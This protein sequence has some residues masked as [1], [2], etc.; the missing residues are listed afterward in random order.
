[1]GVHSALA[2]P[3][4][5]DDDVIGAINSY[6][7]ARDAFSD[8]AVQLSCQFAGPAAVSV[9]NALLLA[10]AWERTERL[11][12]ALGSRAVIDQAVGISRARSGVTAE[13]AFERLTQISQ[14]ENVK[15]HLVAERVVEEAARR[16]R[17]RRQDFGTRTPAPSSIGGPPR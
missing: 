9:Y 4:I 5:V 13:K 16:A 11:Q 1:M 10:G 15:L 8:H 2:L 14:D 3:L 7:H 17:A 12:R 6:A